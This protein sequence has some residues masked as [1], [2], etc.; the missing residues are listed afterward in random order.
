MDYQRNVLK[1]LIE[2]SKTINSAVFKLSR[3]LILALTAY[4]K[5]GLQFREL[6]ALLNVSD[7]KLQSDLNKLREMGYLE[8]FKVEMDTKHVTIYMI[9][10]TGQKEL[11]KMVQLTEL[12]KRGE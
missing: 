1:N 3:F 8:K 5:D 2:D 9:T 12:I 11:T 4:I 6:K 7:G 10:E